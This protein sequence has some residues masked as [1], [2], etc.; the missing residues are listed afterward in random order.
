M[1]NFYRNKVVWRYVSLDA[2]Q[3]ITDTKIIPCDV[4]IFNITKYVNWMETGNVGDG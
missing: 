3:E 2:Q 4:D 1:G